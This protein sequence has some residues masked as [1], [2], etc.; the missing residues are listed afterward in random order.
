MRTRFPAYQPSRQLL[1]AIAALKSAREKR[2]AAIARGT[3]DTPGQFPDMGG[4]AP[5]RAA[6]RQ[7]SGRSKTPGREDTDIGAPAG[8]SQRRIEGLRVLADID[9]L[10]SGREENE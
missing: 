2:R 10:T 8:T 9:A 5:G 6:E 1:D 3:M 4:G 7:T